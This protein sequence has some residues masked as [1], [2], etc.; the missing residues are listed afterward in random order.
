M[1]PSGAVPAS[2]SA[3]VWLLL[4]VQQSDHKLCILASKVALHGANA[5]RSVGDVSYD[6]GD[7]F[8]LQ[9]G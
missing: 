7:L 5:R 2:E 3:S 9:A 6:A 1:L 8:L 4:R